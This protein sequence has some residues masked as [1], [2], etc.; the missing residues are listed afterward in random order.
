M[1]TYKNRLSYRPD[2]KQLIMDCSFILLIIVATIFA[3]WKCK[4]GFGGYDEPFYQ[5]IPHRLTQGDALFKHE[6]NLSLL[7]S[8]LLYPFTWLY[9]TITG[10]TTGILLAARYTYVFAHLAVSVAIYSR[11][12]RFGFASV[13][14]SV[15]YFL[16]TPFNIMALSYNSMGL[17]LITLTG[18]FLATADTSKKLPIILSGVFFAGAVLCQPYVLIA[19]ALFIFCVLINLACTKLKFNN[20]F[21]GYNF[22]LKTFLYFTLGAGIMA[23]LFFI[24][25]LPRTSLADVFGNLPY[26]INDPMHPAMP[27]STILSYYFS[28]IW[29]CTELFKY[30]IIGFGILLVA[31]IADKKRFYHRG[32]YLALTSVVV[33]FA[34]YSLLT[35]LVNYNYNAIMFP[36]LYLGITSYILTKNKNRGLM[37]GLF[38]L[39][40]VFSFAC[41]IAS[42][43]YFYIVSCALVAANVASIIFIGLVVKEMLTEKEYEDEKHVLLFSYD[44]KKTTKSYFSSSKKLAGIVATMV[45]ILTI[46]SQG[47]LQI[48][49]KSTHVFWELEPQYLT[50]TLSGGPADGLLTSEA[51]AQ[52]YQAILSDLQKNFSASK[53]E[54][55]LFLSNNTWAYLAADMNYGTYSAWTQGGG[56]E[57]AVLRLNQYYSFNPDKIPNYVYIPKA[58]N[59]D[60]NVITSTFWGKDYKLTASKIAYILSK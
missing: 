21:T 9:T 12:R 37:A 28:T 19:Y 51:N 5:T 57:T 56:L 29:G 30:S 59:P 22:S 20:F 34:Y 39:S 47:C 14:A 27:L 11:L 16:F 33:L 45:M 26:M 18:V 46:L 38:L 17:D 60:L 2:K 25:L 4:F 10:G 15:L 50:T 3:L 35:N 53:E 8:F 31:I 23:V 48:I 58:D 6:W 41:C 52:N 32:V 36:L 55:V 44:K 1:T 24:F 54:N 49:V 7:S 42:N 43:Q 40:V 13:F